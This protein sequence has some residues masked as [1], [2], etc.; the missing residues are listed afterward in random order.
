MVVIA[1]HLVVGE[2]EDLL[3]GF[4][5]VA[6]RRE[7]GKNEGVVDAERREEDVLCGS[8]LVENIEEV[9]GELLLPF[10]QGL[11]LAGIGTPLMVVRRK[12]L[13]QRDGWQ[14]CQ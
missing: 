5:C 9:N 4:L 13:P 7:V 3:E 12:A 14:H 10:V 11:P 6:P 2:V 1:S 8:V